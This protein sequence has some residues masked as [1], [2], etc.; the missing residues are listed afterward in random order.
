MPP[1]NRLME[2]Q[3]FSRVLAVELAVVEKGGSTCESPA[4]E[5]LMW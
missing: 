1:Q 5:S 4:R 2:P 3:P